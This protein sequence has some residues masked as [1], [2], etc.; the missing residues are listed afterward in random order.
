VYKALAPK[1]RCRVVLQAPDGYTA[2]IN[3]QTVV[4]PTTAA[5][6]SGTPV[7]I[8]TDEPDFQGWHGDYASANRTV[9]FIIRGDVAFKMLNVEELTASPTVE[10]KMISLGD[11]TATATSEMDVAAY[12]VDAN[13]GN[14]NASSR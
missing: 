7:S 14:G 10:V 8:T 4:M 6:P 2:T 5:F 11:L 3:G 9:N 12:P 13:A 1:D